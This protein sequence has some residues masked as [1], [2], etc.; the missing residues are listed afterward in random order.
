[1]EAYTDNK[2]IY[3]EYLALTGQKRLNN[4]ALSDF[5]KT[6]ALGATDR[7]DH[8][9]VDMGMERGLN[10]PVMK[11][12][13]HNEALWLAKKRAEGVHRIKLPSDENKLILKKFKENPTSL[14][15][16]KQCQL[17]FTSEQLTQIT[18]SHNSINYGKVCINSTTSKCFSILNE[19]SNSILVKL[20]GL[21]SDIKLSKP[22][23][24]VIPGGSTVAGFDIIFCGTHLGK[25]RSTFSW[26]VNGLHSFTVTVHAEVVPIEVTLNKDKVIFEFQNESIEANVSE[27]ILISNPGDAVAEYA[28]SLNPGS[29]FICRPDKGI[30]Q[31]G[32]STSV[33]IIW[34]PKLGKKNDADVALTIQGGVTQNLKLEGLL[35]ETVVKFDTKVLQV[36]II[37]VGNESYFTTRLKNIGTYVAVFYV[38]HDEESD[39]SVS[40]DSGNRYLYISIFTRIHMYSCSYI[41]RYVRSICYKYSHINK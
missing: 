41:C 4:K 40:P 20:E 38:N 17:E 36:G 31:P 35:L 15:D 3:N 21:N 13:L 11:V 10:E 9:G 30:L 26:V 22:L 16:I 32:K 28:L 25:V 24:Q 8:L 18:S 6:I 14:T 29:A 2:K 5:K 12:E 23:S 19:L 27:N 7:T 39:V 1:M 34:A 37:A 33:N